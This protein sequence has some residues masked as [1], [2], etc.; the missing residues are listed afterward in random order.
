MRD[1][2]LMMLSVSDNAATGALEDLAGLDA[3]NATLAGLG[4]AGT[5]V[6]V[7][8]AEYLDWIGQDAG[9]TGWAALERAAKAW[10]PRQERDALAG[11]AFDPGQAIRTTARETAMLLRLIWRDEAASQQACE[12]VR[13]LLRRQVTRQRIALGFPPAAVQVAAKSGSLLGLIRNEAGVV[14]FPDG[15]SYA[16]AVFTRAHQQWAGEH[17]INAAIGRA[18]ALAVD[19][20]RPDGPG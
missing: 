5:V 8:L 17:A 12:Q 16:V 19:C 18:A 1:L 2:A 11:R 14:T 10:S 6:P 15:H 3:V 20:L 7:T 9:Y 4:L 13:A